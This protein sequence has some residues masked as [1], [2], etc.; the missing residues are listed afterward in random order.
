MRYLFMVV[1]LAVAMAGPARAAHTI[2]AGALTSD[3]VL[4]PRIEGGALT[5]LEVELRFHADAKGQAR[6]DLPDHW[7]GGRHFYERLQDLTV[8]G[9]ASVDTPEPQTRLIHARPYAAITVHYRIAANLKAGQWPD[10]DHQSDPAVG[11][12]YFHVFGQSIF[13]AV[14][15]R[16][17]DPAT[18]HWAGADGWT[19][20]SALEPA[21]GLR[22]TDVVD[23]AA[24]AGKAVHV[25]TLKTAHTDLR[26]A[27]IGDFSYDLG[28]FNADIGKVIAAEQAFWDN[29]QPAFVVTLSPVSDA[30]QAIRGTGG[31]A[32]FDMMTTPAVPEVMLKTT[33]AH[34]YF[35]TWNPFALGG[36][37]P[38][39][40]SGYWFSEGVTDY[41]GR[42]MALRAGI[43]DL[44]GYVGAWND[45]LSRY[46]ASPVRTAP[47]STI[48][49]DFWSNPEAGFLAYDR[50]SAL[51]VQ[52][53]H[54]WRGKGVTLDRF[55]QA[56][57]EAAK[58]DAAF[59]QKPFTER[60]E[61]VARGLG[62][63]VA[64]DL[65]HHVVEG[66]PVHLSEDAFGGCL[67]V[68]DQ[69][70]AAIDF[71]YDAEKSVA[72]GV[73]T[74]VEPDSNAYRAGLR[75]GMVRLARLGGDPNDSRVPFSFKVRAADGTEK[76]IT[77]L[78]QGQAH[79]TRQQVTIP[80]GL[81]AQALAACT[82]AVAAY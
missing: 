73:F 77:Y 16:D 81:A 66:Q 2:H 41:Y 80:Q 46:A 78:P 60:V 1:G 51:A 17:D 8:A 37:E 79:F 43:I 75:D 65:A 3:Y 42:K 63:D 4:S 29:G 72:S 48:A 55:L 38:G 13:A 21:E 5:A 12:D 71:G 70:V 59:G 52:W 31:R 53:N 14:D 47:N 49:S 11:P 67:K 36:P 27:S 22:V 33:L 25:D 74:G 39:A 45:T 26:I 28:A 20:V 58:A 23:S 50:G 62:I 76:V 61:G 9:A 7:G 6:L 34:E 10:M 54:D 35:H 69:D 19:F 15:G 18:F 40:A 24:I 64:D 32:S 68:A 57:R 82:A 30:G 56:L 44:A